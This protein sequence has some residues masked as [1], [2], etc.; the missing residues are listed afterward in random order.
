MTPSV[1][2]TNNA[3]KL[4]TKRCKGDYKFLKSLEKIKHFIYKDNIEIFAKNENELDTL[5][6]TIR[7][8]SQAIGM[9][10]GI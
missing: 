7:I 8:Y 9:K 1:C 3:T 10:F 5:I 6:Q 2:Y 4:Y